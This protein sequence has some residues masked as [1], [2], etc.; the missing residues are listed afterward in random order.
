[1]PRKDRGKAAAA[2]EPDVF[3]VKRIVDSDAS[4][5]QFLIHWEGY[6]HV[7]SK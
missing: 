6:D 4:N 3:T 7:P 1:M 5:T 2:P